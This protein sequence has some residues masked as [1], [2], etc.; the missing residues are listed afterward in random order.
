M[1]T[2]SGLL[3]VFNSFLLAG[4]FLLATSGCDL[5]GFLFNEESLDHYA[6]PGN[7]IPDSLIEEVSF[8]SDGNTL[9][10]YWVQSNGR[11]PGLTLLYCHGN[12][13]SL[14]EYWDRVMMLYEL[15]I[16]LLIFDYRGFGRSDGEPDEAGLFA[17]GEAAWEFLQEEKAMLPDSLILYGYSLGNVVSIHLAAE[18]VDPL[19][20]IA[21]APFASATS[22]AQGSVAFGLPAGWLTEGN[23][24]N[25]STIERITTP[26]LH[27]HGA[28]DD[29][30][31]FRD[32]GQVVYNHAPQPKELILVPN[33]D[34][35]SIPYEMQIP[36]YLAAIRNWIDLS[37]LHG[38]L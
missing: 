25:A 24:D 22:L 20:M 19:C 18:V 2:K 26:Y 34:H 29:L 1:S 10:G 31:R 30:V 4:I 14:D 17:D 11:R 32:N 23:Y 7:T 15:G 37:L 6:L 27:F 38:E 33:A 21:E 3:S 5:D 9:Y 13:K 35:K 16:N 8:D 12:K 36:V 28:R